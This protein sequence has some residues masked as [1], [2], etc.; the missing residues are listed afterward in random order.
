MLPS[1]LGAIC[2]FESK[3]GVSGNRAG[4]VIARSEMT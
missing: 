1:I 4:N 2:V 3:K